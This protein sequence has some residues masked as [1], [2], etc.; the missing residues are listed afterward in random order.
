VRRNSLL[1]HLPADAQKLVTATT[2]QWRE[3]G[4][5][6]PVSELKDGRLHQSR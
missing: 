4:A 1:E 3:S 2:M 5:E 6:G